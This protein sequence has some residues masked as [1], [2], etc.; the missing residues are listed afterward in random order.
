MSNPIAVAGAGPRLA[1]SPHFLLLVAA[2]CWAGNLVIGKLA[3]HGYVPPFALSFWR[4]VLAAAILLPFA[5]RGLRR[6]LPLL[7]GRWVFVAVLGTLSVGTY[8]TAQYWGLQH[9]SA[10]NTSVLLA[11]MPA[12]I[13]FGTWI[14][15]QERASGRQLAGLVAAT[16]GVLTVAFQGSFARA[17]AF[18]FNI[19]DI[20]IL[21]GVA[22]W[23]VYSIMLRRLPPGLD[24]FG[25]LLLCILVGL[26][27][28]APFWIWE[29]AT[30]PLPV[31]T[32]SSL[33]IVLYTAIFPA[34]I[35]YICWNRAIALGG[36]NLA[37]IMN[38]LTTVFA[39]ILAI[40]L[41]G[42]RPQWHHGAGILLVFAG[43]YLAV[44]RRAAPAGERGRSAR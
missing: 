13:F 41:L 4:W 28:I 18:S 23:V 31:V 29:L 24:P 5:W 12:F 21:A 1:Q 34:L 26:P 7:K 19:G 10:L 40:A 11:S 44:F 39:V 25:L 16:A 30:Q 14:A 20:A 22:G 33:G 32:A 42:E 15:G 27:A 6:N 2:L 8:N 38:T 36:A 37:G 9:T 35:A 3:T 43:L 17:L